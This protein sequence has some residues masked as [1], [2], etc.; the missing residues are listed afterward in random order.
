M[1]IVSCGKMPSCPKCGTFTPPPA[2]FCSKCG[3]QIYFSYNDIAKLLGRRLPNFISQLG[4]KKQFRGD[5]ILYNGGVFPNKVEK[6]SVTY[7]T[8]F[9]QSYYN[10][11][12]EL[13]VNLE[14][15]W[16]CD[17]PIN[18]Y[19]TKLAALE[20]AEIGI[21]MNV[22]ESGF[23]LSGR[24]QVRFEVRCKGLEG[25]N[26]IIDLRKPSHLGKNVAITALGFAAG[27]ATAVATGGMGFGFFGRKNNKLV[28]K[29][30]ISKNSSSERKTVDKVHYKTLFPVRKLNSNPLSS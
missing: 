3:F 16:G 26:P 7:L 5:G 9:V 25:S 1:Y 6:G 15:A 30:E 10:G 23:M 20:V 28:C 12:S 18:D 2:Y 21:P 19:T 4:F 14:D 29:F 11:L 13:N 8:L 22:K 24:K 27:I 17:L